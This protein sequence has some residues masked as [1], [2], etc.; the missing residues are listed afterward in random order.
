MPIDWCL[1]RTITTL[2]KIFLQFN[3]GDQNEKG[4]RHFTTKYIL[5]IILPLKI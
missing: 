5:D 2:N 1:P 3:Y 4:I